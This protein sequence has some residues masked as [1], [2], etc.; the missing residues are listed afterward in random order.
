MKGRTLATLV[1]TGLVAAAL[2]Q[3][4]RKP[5][6]E[7][8]W[9]GR[10]GGIVPYDFRRPTLERIREAWWSPDDPRILTERVFGVGWTVNLGRVTRLAQESVR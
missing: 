8:T 9:H 3:E 7:R 5:E 4:L 10:L 2:A 6:D 1:G